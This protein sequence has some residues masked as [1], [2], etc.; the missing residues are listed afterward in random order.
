MSRHFFSSL[1]SVPVKVVVSL[2]VV[3]V[4]V[5][6][7]VVV[8]VVFAVVV[9]V[10]GHQFVPSSATHLTLMALVLPSVDWSLSL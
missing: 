3:V 5:F 7:V 2:V 6:V 1:V 9:V 8:V 10:V 4:V